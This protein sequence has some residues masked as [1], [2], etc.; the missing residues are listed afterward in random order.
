MSYLSDLGTFLKGEREGVT[1]EL[2][3][4]LNAIAPYS[5][6]L[7]VSKKLDNFYFQTSS[8]FI[9]S[10]ADKNR[11]VKFL[12]KVVD[13]YGPELVTNGDFSNGLNGL[14]F[15]GGSC[16]LVNGSLFCRPNAG[17][18]LN[19]SISLN[20]NM[21]A[22]KT[23]RIEYS[24][25]ET[26]TPYFF[27]SIIQGFQQQKTGRFVQYV[28][29]S[30]NLAS[31]DMGIGGGNANTYIIIDNISVREI[32]TINLSNYI[33]ETIV[34]DEATN[35][36]TLQTSV[37]AGDYVVV[38]RIVQTG[39]ETYRAKIDAPI[40]TS[41]TNTTYF[42]VRDSI[43]VTNQIG[44][45]HKYN[46]LTNSYEGLSAE[47]LFSDV[48]K[49][50]LLDNPTW[51]ARN[52]FSKAGE[53]CYSKGTYLYLP[54][55]IWQTLNKGAYHPVFNGFGTKA[56]QTYLGNDAWIWYGYES[57]KLKSLADSYLCA[58]VNSYNGGGSG[59]IL[60]NSTYNG[61]QGY[62]GIQWTNTR[63]DSKYY[64]IVYPDQV[65]DIREYGRILNKWEVD[66][67]RADKEENSV[68]EVVFTK[69]YTGV[70]AIKTYV[71][72]NGYEYAFSSAINPYKEYL[73]HYT[74][75]KTNGYLVSSSGVIIE[76][77]E[78][79]QNYNSSVYS[80]F[81]KVDGTVNIGDTVTVVYNDKATIPVLSSNTKLSTDLIGNPTNYPQA[82]KDRLAEGKG[83]IGINSLLV[84]DLGNNLIPDGTSKNYK[85]SNKSIT[86][87]VG[88]YSTNNGLTYVVDS[89]MV[90]EFTYI[91]N[92]RLSWA[93]ATGFLMLINYTSKNNPYIQTT[94]KAVVEVLPKVKASNSHSI[95]KG[96]LVGNQ[97]SGKIQVGNGANGYESKVLE[98]FT[99]VSTYL[100]SD[101]LISLATG[102]TILVVD[103]HLGDIGMK[104]VVGTIYK[105]KASTYY[106]SIDTNALGYSNT[107][108]YDIVSTW[109]TIPTHSTIALDNSNSPA[110]KWF[111]V[112]EEGN[113]G[114]LAGVYGKE[115]IWD[116][117]KDQISDVVVS[118]PQSTSFYSKGT[119]YYVTDGRF[120]GTWECLV[121]TGAP[122]SEVA[123]FEVDDVIY[124]SNSILPCF[125]R[126]DGN[127]FGD[128]D[129][130]DQ[131]TNGTKTDLNGNTVRT[132][133]GSIAI[134][135]RI[136]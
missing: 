75:L 115:L 48:S 136:K 88:I 26:T 134:N 25:L 5:G 10:M 119:I 49:E 83:I 14:A 107:S 7:Q 132:F 24:V 20:A 39:A 105:Y 34:Q 98:N 79:R 125:K 43:G 68:E 36:F 69:A 135:G 16:S 85:V 82:M 92:A 9:A 104:G 28:T 17:L 63:P 111:E 91:S 3:N 106:P 64:D 51:L 113:N 130:F 35:G 57:K 72:G 94:P 42:E 117:S 15:S 129:T 108:L 96:A 4:K 126:W 128:N 80:R 44:V 70:V 81:D 65:I 110:S 30:N 46:V 89:G 99:N 73:G 32:Q 29:V 53:F 131:L 40:G 102:D 123:F 97:V 45:F 87:F 93:P 67:I 103:G 19:I 31:I 77:S 59:A 58:T 21:S 120:N 121:D 2:D 27:I 116:F 114:V 55:S 22:G 8:N 66:L 124:Y 54:V 62:N 122:L 74:D 50:D 86:T 90:S 76:L 101:G 127:G 118:V 1:L 11:Y 84:D 112:L 37:N 109:V 95:Y 100:S 38:D 78:I 18:Q 33:P 47:I 52:G 6:Y 23:Y 41:L 12:D 133:H 61:N 71:G 60:T 56:L 13:T